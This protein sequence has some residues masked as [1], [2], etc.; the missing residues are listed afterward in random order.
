MCSTKDFVISGRAGFGFLGPIAKVPAAVPFPFV[1]GEEEFS[2]EGAETDV[3][4]GGCSE[5]M[6]ARS[7]WAT[8]IIW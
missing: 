1:G 8:W 2:A 6:A 7:V 5:P 4:A 3:G